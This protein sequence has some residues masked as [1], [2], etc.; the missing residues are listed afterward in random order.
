MA[1]RMTGGFR[2]DPQW[3]ARQARTAG[4]VSRISYDA[5]DEMYEIFG[6]VYA[7]RQASEERIFRRYTELNRGL[8]VIEDPETGER[9]EVPLGSNYWW[10]LDDAGPLLGTEGALPPDLPG[11]WVRQMRMRR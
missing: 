8:T 2:M 5:Q 1:V 10:R 9:F 3:V 7:D 11:Y 6:Q 4:Q